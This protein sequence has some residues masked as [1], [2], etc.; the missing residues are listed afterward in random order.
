MLQSGRMPDPKSVTLLLR[1]LKD[2]QKD[3]IDELVPMVYQELHRMAAIHLNREKTG[4]TLQATALV[5]EAYMRLI[6]DEAPDFESRNHFFGVASRVMRQILVDHARARSAAKR[7]GVIANSPIEHAINYAN[8]RPELLVSLDDALNL[9]EKQD[10]LKARIIEQK[11][12]GGLTAEES[13]A[14]LGMPIHKLNR[15]IR[16]AQAWLRREMGNAPSTEEAAVA[17]E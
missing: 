1:Q 12:F 3:A 14:L 7:G 17:Q 4:H 10:P 5:N 8:E 11:Y 16:L 6:K 13:A 9:L 2:G 15:E